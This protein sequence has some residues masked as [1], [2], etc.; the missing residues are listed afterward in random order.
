MTYQAYPSK[1]FSS[2]YIPQPTSWARFFEPRP[3][4]RARFVA[5]IKRVAS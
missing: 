2:P 5:F 1:F 4:R 3:T